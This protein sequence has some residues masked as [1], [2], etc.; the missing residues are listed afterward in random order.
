VLLR[1]SALA[2]TALAVIASVALVATPAAAVY[3]ADGTMTFSAVAGSYEGDGAALAGFC[4]SATAS[5]S[6]SSV[7][8]AGVT[9]PSITY[10]G[11]GGGDPG[12][13]GY[14]ESVGSYSVDPLVVA[15]G[16]DVTFTASCL[17]GGGAALATA[18]ST[19]TTY[20]T[21]ST[22]SAPATAAI[23][24]TLAVTG[25]CLDPAD[26]F[27]AVDVDS[28]ALGALYD[29]GQAIVPG[30]WS[31]SFVLDPVV[32]L[33]VGDTLTVTATCLDPA[34]PTVHSVR[35]ATLTL[36]A[37]PAAPGPGAGQGLAETGPDSTPALGVAALL[38]AT[39]AAVLL[40]VS[41]R[42]RGSLAA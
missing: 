40:A 32:G 29:D 42:R 41:R 23:G 24:S 27:V 30:P 31:S 11:D 28:T 5:V 37:A 1:K 16:S 38:L 36:T 19:V 4:P 26:V 18:S 20:T 10:H 33:T 3:T 2:A 21:G 7:P 6:V 25:T 9:L 35:V 34:G 15:P 17:D 13:E 14:F 8:V 22:L 39:G 12:L